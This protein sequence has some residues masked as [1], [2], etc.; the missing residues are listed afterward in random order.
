MAAGRRQAVGWSCAGNGR[1]RSDVDGADWASP[2]GWNGNPNV[3][4]VVWVHLHDTFL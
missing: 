3:I 4:F 2:S 1:A